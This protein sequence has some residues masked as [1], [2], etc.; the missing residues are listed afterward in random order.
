MR[1][2]LL[3]TKISCRATHDYL[4]IVRNAGRTAQTELRRSLSAWLA[5]TSAQ[6]SGDD[7]S[8]GI[9]YQTS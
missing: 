2:H 5:A 8:V 7:I 4:A 3:V 6:G 9:L 1:I